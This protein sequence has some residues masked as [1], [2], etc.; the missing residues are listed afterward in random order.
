MRRFVLLFP[1]ILLV[2]GG[3]PAQSEDITPERILL[4]LER[5]L[6]N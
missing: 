2:A 6:K 3:A 5:G 4:V 1:L